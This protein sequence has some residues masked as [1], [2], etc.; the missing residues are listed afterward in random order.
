MDD[1][2]LAVGDDAVAARQHR[3]RV[4]VRQA[5]GQ[6]TQFGRLAVERLP[7]RALQSRRQRLQMQ[8]LPRQRRALL[9]DRKSVV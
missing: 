1:P 5:G 8:R 2:L 9:S 6:A 4:E 3:P 7:P